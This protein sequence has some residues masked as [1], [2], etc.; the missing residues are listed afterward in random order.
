MAVEKET[1]LEAWLEENMPEPGGG[2]PNYL[3]TIIGTLNYPFGSYSLSEIK[4]MLESDDYTLKVS[5]PKYGEVEC[6]IAVDPNNDDV[7][8]SWFDE[9][10]AKVLT[11]CKA[12]YEIGS[13]NILEYDI[14]ASSN[15]GSIEN[16]S[17]PQMGY[18]TVE[19]LLKVIHHPLPEN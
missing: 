5:L 16:V 18:L 13:V 15:Y 9:A 1:Q 2:N 19:T 8:I 4:T 14:K 10:D 3:E 6:V 12:Y 7:V 11:M 17:D